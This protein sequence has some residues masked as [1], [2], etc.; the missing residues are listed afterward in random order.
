VVVAKVAAETA[1]AAKVEVMVVEVR[2]EV[3]GLLFIF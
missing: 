1:A 2:A 3:W